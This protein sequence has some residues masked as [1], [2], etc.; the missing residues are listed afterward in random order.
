MGETTTPRDF[1]KFKVAAKRRNRTPLTDRSYWRW[2]YRTNEPVRNDFTVEEIEEII[3]SGDIE[4]M[5]ELSRYFYRTNGEYRNNVDLLAHLPLYDTAVIPVYQ[6]GK[7][8]EKNLTKGFYAACR[9]VDNLSVK[10]TF[11]HITT[12]WIKTGLYN[13]ILRVDGDKVT[14][15]D[16]PAHYC[17]SRFK[18]FNNLNILEFNLHYFDRL[19]EEARWEAVLTFPKEVQ[20]AYKRWISA[21]KYIEPWV[22]LPAASGGINFS[23]ITDQTPLL[24]ASIPELKKLQDAVGREEKRDEN[25]LYKLLI[26]RMPI[27][28]KGEL[29]FQLDEVAEIHSSVADMLSDIDTV[30]VLTTFG[31]TDLENLQDSSN[32]T[33]SSDRIAKYKTNAYD[34]L[35][36][37]SLI[38]NADGSAALAYAI[39]KDE[40]LVRAYLNVYEHWIKFHLNDRFAKGG[41]T[42][43]FAIM[44]TTVFNREEILNSTFRG[45]QYGYSKM[46]AGVAMG[47]PQMDQLSLMHF[48][49]E[50][51]DMTEKMIPLQSSYTSSNTSIV[52]RASG[53]KKATSNAASD[54][55]NNKGGRPELPDEQKSE[56]TQANIAAAEG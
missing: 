54:D 40:A 30:D 21:P 8:S 13:G 5:R 14:I 55:L 16:L 3:R 29:V 17:R 18:D 23:F 38:F 24:I 28:N 46:L 50:V 33:Q 31:D 53:E 12:E 47:I 4:A 45:A 36:R 1:S 32:A 34:A 15:Q 37:S 49:N 10:N 56:K 2:G 44:P 9:F 52:E 20:R 27:D 19:P 41:L 51:L 22:E 26:Q 7:V 11:T 35:G 6:V 43:D 25:E 39:K 42:F 48:E